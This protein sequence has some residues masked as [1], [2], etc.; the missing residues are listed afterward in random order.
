MRLEISLKLSICRQASSPGTRRRSRD[1]FRAGIGDRRSEGVIHTPRCT[2]IPAL[3]AGC[4]PRRRC[5]PRPM[6]AN[7]RS[8][9]GLPAT[10][11][12]LPA[13]RCTR[14]PALSARSLPNG[15]PRSVCGLP[16]STAVLPTPRCTRVPAPSAR[17]LPRR[18]SP[19]CLRAACLD[20]GAPARRSTRIPTLS[21]RTRPMRLSSPQSRPARRTSLSHAGRS[22]AAGRRAALERGGRA[23]EGLTSTASTSEPRPMG[24]GIETF[25][26]C[27]RP[28]TLLRTRGGSFAAEPPPNP[29]LLPSAPAW[30]RQLSWR[31]WVAGGLVR[32]PREN[33][34]TFGGRARFRSAV[35]EASQQQRAISGALLDPHQN[36][37]QDGFLPTFATGVVFLQYPLPEHSSP[38][39]HVL[40]R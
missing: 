9:C 34:K 21:A 33:A 39:S 17:Y 14:I 2:R 38:S 28:A 6:H 4:L 40:L 13:P 22:S 7:S 12:V 36:F 35:G 5:S 29:A 26:R 10:T 8:V 3:S 15:R 32:A 31:L 1:R 27:A 23:R 20:G 25:P 37:H 18:R 19:L 16:A 11:A 30:A 24:A